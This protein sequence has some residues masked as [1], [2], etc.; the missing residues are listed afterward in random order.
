MP[1]GLDISGGTRWRRGSASGFRVGVRAGSTSGRRARL[2]SL[3]PRAL[4][5]D[6]TIRSASPR[7]TPIVSSPAA[8]TRRVGGSRAALP[9]RV[10]RSS[11]GLPAHRLHLSRRRPREAATRSTFRRQVHREMVLLCG[12]VFSD[13]SGAAAPCACVDGHRRNGHRW[14][15]ASDREEGRLGHRYPRVGRLSF[16][17]CLRD[18][19]AR[20]YDARRT[21][22][23][24]RLGRT[25]CPDAPRCALSP[26]SR[27]RPV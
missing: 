23:P 7:L 9:T 1:V 3:L 27:E 20:I 5:I 24:Q 21:D 22:G 2:L 12:G 15:C 10:D 13:R 17:D 16:S 11:P 19:V 25:R 14:A 26:H 6:P 8:D 18:R 4:E